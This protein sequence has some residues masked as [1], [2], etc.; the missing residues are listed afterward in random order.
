MTGLLTKDEV[1]QLLRVSVRSVD[2]LRS[3]GLLPAIRLMSMVRFE[4]AAL[5]RFIEGQ[6]RDAHLPEPDA[7]GSQDSTRPD[8]SA[9]DRPWAPWPE[10]G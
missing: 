7:A 9:G 6:R 2:R 8:L 4:A 3:R 10:R 1:A 5:Q